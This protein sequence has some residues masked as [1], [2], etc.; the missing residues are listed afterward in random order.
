MPSWMSNGTPSRD[1]TFALPFFAGTI[2]DATREFSGALIKLCSAMKEGSLAISS[3]AKY[4]PLAVEAI[5]G[6]PMAAR[7]GLLVPLT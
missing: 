5:V 4:Q 1:S 3:P 6:S 7:L 2:R